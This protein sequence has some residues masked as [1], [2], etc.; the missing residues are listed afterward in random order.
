MQD[1]DLLDFLLLYNVFISDLHISE[2]QIIMCSGHALI[3]LQEVIHN[4]TIQAATHVTLL[5]HLC[6]CRSAPAY[7]TKWQHAA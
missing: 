1:L 2:R 4:S 6:W 3:E 7:K 5:L